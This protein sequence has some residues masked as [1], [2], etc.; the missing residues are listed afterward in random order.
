MSDKDLLETKIY[1]R[2]IT[3]ALTCANDIAVRE[4]AKVQFKDYV[5]ILIDSMK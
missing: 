4:V 2:T 1:M 3:D 5:K